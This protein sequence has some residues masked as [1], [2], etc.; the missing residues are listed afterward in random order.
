MTDAVLTLS[1]PVQASFHHVKTVYP[2]RDSVSD[3]VLTLFPTV[4]AC[5]HHAKQ[6]IRT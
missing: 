4:K 1:L 3:A 5:F 6:F 2:D